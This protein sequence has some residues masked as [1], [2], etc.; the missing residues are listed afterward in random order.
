MGYSHLFASEASL[1]NFRA[2]YDVPG[3]VDIAYCH[4][5][6]IAL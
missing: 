4:K 6:D 5:S 2:V 1:A 3:D